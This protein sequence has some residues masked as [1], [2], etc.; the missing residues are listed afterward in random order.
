[1]ATNP[2]A[3]ELAE[4]RGLGITMILLSVVVFSLAGVFTKG[5][6]T[7]S[8]EVIFWRGVFSAGFIIAYTMWRRR[9][10]IEFLKMGNS[11]LAVAAIGAAATACFLTAFKHTSIANVILVYSAAPI[12]AAVLAWLWIGERVSAKTAIA[13]V[14]AIVGVAIIM[15]G[16]FGGG[17]LRGDILALGMTIGMAILMV[18]YR[19]W[20][21]TPAAGPAALGS[22]LLLIPGFAFGNVFEVPQSDFTILVTFGLTFAIASVALGEGM[23]RIPAGE[24]ALLSI[25][26]T[27]LAPLFGF[28][29]FTEIPPVAT[30]VGGGLILAAVIWSQINKKEI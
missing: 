19:R 3:A 4:Q 17:N 7:G 20:P 8:W 11:G 29:F 16:S 2:T 14:V 12:F 24:A 22:L 21:Q 27:P 10:E 6:T 30:F 28:L 26:E 1:M 13:C 5:V 18:I 9:F 25:L 23:K 15:Q